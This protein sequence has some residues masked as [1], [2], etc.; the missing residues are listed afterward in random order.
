MIV[1]SKIRQAYQHLLRYPSIGKGISAVFGFLE[2]P[3]LDL[4][5]WLHKH[6]GLDFYDDLMRSMSRVYGSR[7]IPLDVSIDAKNLV[8]PTEEILGLVRR[9]EGLSLGYCYCR[10][11][12][13]NCENEVWT[14]IHVGTAE[15]IN[16]LATR[17]PTR[18]ATLEDVERIIKKANDAGLVHQLI[19]A[20][21]SEYFYV[22]CNC[23]PCC[24]VMLNSSIRY[25]IKNTAISSNFIIRKEEEKCKNCGVCIT[26]CHFGAHVATK[27][28]VQVDS[29][30][31]AG[32][33][34]CVSTCSEKALSM[35]R[36]VESINH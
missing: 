6:T 13:R 30:R 4:F 16:E 19:T 20:P 7:V 14:C 35:I 22:I 10:S 24:C 23:C 25:G 33:G 32:C 15:S 5:A 29:S 26:R 1:P 28:G 21:N 11:K 3:L 34:L 36:R 18:S 8:S 31:C 2:V 9:V 12:Y 17:K 27:E